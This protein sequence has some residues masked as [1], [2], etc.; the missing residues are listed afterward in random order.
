MVD[1]TTKL[2][3]RRRLRKSRRQVEGIGVQAEEQFERH[4]VRRLGRLWFV[5]RFIASWVLLL[6]ILSSLTIGQLRALSPHYQ[7]LKPVPGGAYAEGMV[8]TFTNA[9]PLYATG[10]VDS[11]IARLVFAG[12]FKF[13]D[14]N[15]LV[16]DLAEKYEV[17]ERGRLYTVT[18]RKGL[19]WH[20]GRQLTAADVVFTYKTIQNPDAKSPLASSWADITVSKIDDHTILFELPNSLSAFPYSMTNGIVPKHLLDGRPV[21]ELRSVSF[22]TIGPVGA[23]PFRWD[24]IEVTG[25]T[26][27]DREQRIALVPYEHYHFGRPKLNRFVIRSFNNEERMLE[28]FRNK[29]LNGMA[30]LEQLPDVFAQEAGIQEYAFPLTSQ[31]MTFFKTSAE[32][33]T[34]A[35]VRRALALAARPDDAIDGIGY[36]LTRV[37]SPLLNTHVGYNPDL[38]QHEPNKEEAARLLDEA[39]WL[40]GEDGLR[41]K[42]GKPLTFRMFSLSTNEYSHVAQRLADQWREAGVDVQVFL[43]SDTDLQAT[44]SMHNYD[45]LLYGISVG[46]DPD[47]FAF[48]H[49]SQADV[50]SVSRLNLA[51]YKSAAADQALEAGRTRDDASLR[52]VKYKPFLEAWRNDAPALALYQPR[53]LYI[54]RGD[55]HNL[56]PHTINAG[57]D[58]FNSVHDWMIL[59]AKVTK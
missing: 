54:T 18:L 30:G 3:W 38:V 47:V 50:R 32:P 10:N 1:H 31:V 21:S 56:Q 49:S 24:K 35:K 52:A 44:L 23:G 8:G 13:D 19:E 5:R 9:N 53:F 33:F 46:V 15:Q 20:D 45:A 17:D 48:W 4:F 12:L 58:R 39:G 36:S 55:V 16:G 51:E 26:P 43:Q 29:E 37:R 14:S 59:E 25:R 2:R 6:I 11:A 57:V 40:M 27:T 42:D 34:D 28:S 7:A 41:Q 22:N